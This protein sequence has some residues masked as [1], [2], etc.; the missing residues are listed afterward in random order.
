MHKEID[1][2][3]YF[4]NDDLRQF[5]SLNTTTKNI[6]ELG[7]LNVLIILKDGRNLTDYLDIENPEDVIFIS[8]DLSGLKDADNYYYLGNV[9]ERQ[10]GDDSTVFSWYGKNPFRN[11][12]A[13]VCQGLTDCVTSLNGTFLK[14]DNVRTISGLDTWDVGNVCEMQSMFGECERLTTVPGIGDWDVCNASNMGWMFKYCKSLKDISFLKSWDVGNVKF[15][16]SMFMKCWSIESIDALNDWDVGNVCDMSFMF[17]DC[18]SLC[19]IAALRNWKAS[20]LE[21]MNG[22]FEECLKLNDDSVTDMKYFEAARINARNSDCN[23]K[24]IY[25]GGSNFVL[26]TDLICMD[27][28]SVVLK[29]SEMLCPECGGDEMIY[30]E[31]GLVCKRCGLVLHDRIEE[32]IPFIYFDHENK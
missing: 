23:L 5:E 26:D 8:E 25:C 2:S 10:Y 21:T 22:M 28:G 27:C 17:Y 12:R 6:Y 18:R 16:K 19:D 32:V 24:C 13:I 11:V 14:L 1:E 20:S 9:V 31:W 15:M 4:Y 29:A 7:D 3:G 30:D